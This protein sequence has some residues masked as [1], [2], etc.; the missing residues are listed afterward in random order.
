MKLSSLKRRYLLASLISTGLLLGFSRPAT[1]QFSD[2][3]E[4]RRIEQPVGVKVGAAITGAGL[5]GL[6]LWWFL[7]SKPK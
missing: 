2:A 6:E 5:V 4:F 7:M 1:A 3:V